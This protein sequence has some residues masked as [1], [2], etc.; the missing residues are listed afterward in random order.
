MPRGGKRDGAGRKPGSV[1][2]LDQEARQ[3]VL[4]G[5]EETPLQFMLRVM[6][7]ASEDAARRLDAAKAAAPYVHARLSAVD[8]GNKD[9]KPFQHEVYGWAQSPAEAIP[10]PS[11]EG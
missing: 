2:R 3:A 4:E 9:G 1:N 7:D 8:V 11:R 5:E 6:R 10:D